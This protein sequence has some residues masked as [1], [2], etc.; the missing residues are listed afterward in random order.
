MS[1]SGI[2]EQEQQWRRVGCGIGVTSGG[3]GTA[4]WAMTH[5]GNPGKGSGTVMSNGATTGSTSMTI[6]GKTIGSVGSSMG[7]RVGGSGT[8]GSMWISGTGVMCRRGWGGWG[9]VGMG[10]GGGMGGVGWTVGMGQ[11]IGGTG[12]GKSMGELRWWGGEQ[13]GT[14]EHGGRDGRREDDDCG[15][16]NVRDMEWIGPGRDG[17]DGMGG[18]CVAIGSSMRIKGGGS[19]SGSSMVGCIVSVGEGWGQ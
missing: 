4:T 12:S 8:Q 6:V 3:I 1:L 17:R 7:S 19:G 15:K 14:D 16:W 18:E 9:G 10:N 5:D 11:V 13:W 2:D